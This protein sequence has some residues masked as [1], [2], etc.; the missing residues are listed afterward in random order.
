MNDKDQQVLL[1][2]RMGQ[3]RAA[4]EEAQVLLSRRKT[5]LGA[6]NRAYYAM[7]YAVLALLQHI[8][9]IPRKHSG[10]LALFDSEFVKK[11]VFSMELSRHLHHAFESRQVSDYQ[12]MEP[13]SLEEAGEILN[14]AQSFVQAIERYLSIN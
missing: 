11:G 13:I 10:V 12:A 14:N 8:G 9:K 7:F 4:L 2:F 1:G 5:S 3:A 6:V